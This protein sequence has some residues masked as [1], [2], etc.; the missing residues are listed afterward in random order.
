MSSLSFLYYLKVTVK[1]EQEP[2]ATQPDLG[3]R[4]EFGGLNQV[5]TVKL[6][7]SHGAAGCLEQRLWLLFG[8]LIYRLF[9]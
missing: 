5:E 6:S 8:R 9:F 4:Y 2:A 7:E 1:K 3:P